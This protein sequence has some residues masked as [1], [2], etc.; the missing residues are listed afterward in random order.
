M[1]FVLFNIQCYALNIQCYTQPHNRKPQKVQSMTDLN[2]NHVA[3][4]INKY[5]KQK[6]NGEIQNQFTH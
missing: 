6:R 5:Q 1:K 2:W 4:K 3:R